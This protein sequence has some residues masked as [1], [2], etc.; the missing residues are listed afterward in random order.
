MPMALGVG[1]ELHGWRGGDR[2]VP[3]W[4][5]VSVCV[6]LGIRADAHRS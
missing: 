5:T 1:T 2:V 6:S 4:P 3:V